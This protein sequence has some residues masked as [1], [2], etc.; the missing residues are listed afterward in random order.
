MFPPT[1]IIAPT[2]DNALPR[3]DKIHVTSE[4]LAS[5]SRVKIFFCN[6]V[7][8]I[9]KKSSYSLL[10]ISKVSIEIDIIIGR[11]III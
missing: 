5:H 4:N 7:L 2:S 3:P 10:I 9:K 6:V 1:I 11:I 8:N